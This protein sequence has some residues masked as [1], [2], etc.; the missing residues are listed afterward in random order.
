MAK[1]VLPEPNTMTLLSSLLVLFPTLIISLAGV[2]LV[3]L[4]LADS[5]QSGLLRLGLLLLV[6]Y[7]L[8]MLAYRF[9]AWRYPLVEGISY[10]QNQDYSPWWGSHQI[11]AI[12]IAFPLLEAG[13]RLIPGGFSAWL[14]LWGSHIGRHVYWTPGLEIADRGLLTIGDRVVLGHRVGLYSHIIKPKRQNLL[15]YIKRVAIGDDTFIG[16]G[17]HLGPGVVIAP[18]TQLNAG[19]NLYL[20]QAV[21]GSVAASVAPKKAAI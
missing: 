16:A 11:Q 13:L 3:W 7:G 15:L 21:S 2:D 20:N 1:A 9:H 12:Y 5:W 17:S 10:L 8:P 19:S 4:C 18:G 6:L 14:R